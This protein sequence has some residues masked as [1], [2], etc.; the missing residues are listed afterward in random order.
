MPAL[1][2][3]L[4][5]FVL[6][7][8][9]FIAVWVRQLTTRNAGMVDPVWSWSMGAMGV[10]YALAGSADWTSRCTVGV[11]AGAW[12][13]RL[14]THLYLRNAGK[15]EDGRYRRLREDWGVMADRR[16]LQFFIFQAVAASI[17]SLGMWAVCWQPL[18]PE[19]WQISAAIMLA[20]ISLGGEAIADAQLERFRS[21]PENKG[22][23]CRGG[24]WAWSRHPNYFFECLHWF[25]YSLL[26]WGTPWV[27]LTLVPPIVMAWLL[28]KVSG[29]PANEAEAAAKRPEYA[30]Y[31]RTTSA[32]IPLP[33]RRS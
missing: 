27:W 12:G 2:A 11:I 7:C 15:P 29:I 8:M 1:S 31:I 26:A 25:C 22:R 3:L 32:F 20:I 23:V 19:T 24:L 14:G 13:L 30:E 28:L 18:E 4:L 9:A 21:N 16:M 6:C 10:L 33:P 5:G 17:L